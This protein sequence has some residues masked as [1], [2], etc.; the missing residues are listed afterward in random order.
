VANNRNVSS[1]PTSIEIGMAM[2]KAISTPA[3]GD[4]AG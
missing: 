2:A 3:A 4:G 1:E